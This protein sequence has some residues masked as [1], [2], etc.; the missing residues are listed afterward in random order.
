MTNSWQWLAETWWYVPARCL[1]ALQLET[2]SGEVQWLDNQTVWQIEGSRYGYFWGKAAAIYIP[3]CGE[4]SPRGI[5][6]IG[7]VMPEGRVH[8]TFPGVT[9]GTGEMKWLEGQW[10]FALQMSLGLRNVNAHWAYMYQTKPGEDSWESLPGIHKSVPEFFAAAFDD[11]QAP[12][13]PPDSP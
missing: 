2:S 5:S 11:A 4:A 12:E 9:V 6:L 10:V 8:L 1:P 13:E 3:K 7:T